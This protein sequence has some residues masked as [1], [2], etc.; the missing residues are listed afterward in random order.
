MHFIRLVLPVLLIC[1]TP[2]FAQKTNDLIRDLQRDVATMQQDVK[3]LNSKFDE[4]I[5]IISTLLQQALNEAGSAAKGV[6]VL[7]RQIKD[8]L[9]EQSTLVAAPVANLG[10]KVEAMSGEYTSLNENVKDLTT[11]LNKMQ[12]TLTEMYT[13]MKTMNAPPAPPP[14]AG[15]T[16]AS[17]PAPPAGATPDIVFTQ[18]TRDKEAGN[19]DLAIAEFSDFL[20]F[21]PTNDR[22]PDAQF[23]LGETHYLLKKDYEAAIQVFDLMIEKYP[24]HKKAPDAMYLKGRALMM[25]DQRSKAKQVFTDLIKTYPSTEAARKAKSVVS[26]MASPAP[27]K[28]R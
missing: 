16:Q 8:N 13:Y 17:G 25:A 9:K 18:A 12:S 24:D 14:N 21:W 15:P 22:A 19:A 28:R 23:Y 6:A 2:A 5:A 4:K 1:A 20:R 11:R 10:S 26:A 27:K 3:T 7:D